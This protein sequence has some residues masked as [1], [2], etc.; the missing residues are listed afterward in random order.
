LSKIRNP[1]LKAILQRLW[2][3]Q[4]K[5]GLQGRIQREYGNSADPE[6]REV[7]AYLRAHPSQELPLGV[8]PPY[9]WAQQYRPEDV[10]VEADSA[11]GLLVTVVNGHRIFFPR[12]ATPATVQRSVFNAR[13]EQDLRSPH[14]YLGGRHT[15]DPGDVAAFVGASDGIFCQSVIE[16][17]SKAYLF[18]PDPNWTEPLRTT[19]KPW[20]E[21]VEIV[22]KALGSRDVDGVLRLDSF[23]AGRLRPNFI[24]IDVEGAELEILKGAEHLL[25]EAEKLRLSICTYHR[26]LD[27]PSF[28]KRLTRL[29]YDIGHSP[30]F[31]IIGV[32]MP[33]L[34]R[35]V[36]YASRNA[37]QKTPA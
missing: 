27:F 20:G 12:N 4:R 10:A 18:E 26:R 25:R 32:R 3:Q 2:Y 28:A 36:I 24:Q 8:N 6:V 34:R 31:Y 9:D 5:I 11:T 7:L 23:L 30:G 21:K 17:L 19:M 37:D 33:Y 29:G 15:V 1:G 13:M 35:G 16:R 14:C 22:P